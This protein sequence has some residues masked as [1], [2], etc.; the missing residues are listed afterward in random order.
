MPI[1]PPNSNDSFYPFRKAVLRGLGISMPPLLTI[2]LFLWAWTLIESYVLV[3]VESVAEVVITGASRDVL[4]TLP[5]PE[6]V[7][8]TE[9]D[10]PR[11]SREGED[12]ISFHF[13]RRVYTRSGE[14]RWVGYYPREYVR[15]N[16]TTRAKILPPFVGGLLLVLYLLGKFVAAG[17]GR[18]L[19]GFFDRLILQLPL[20]SNVYSAVKQVTDFVFVDREIEFN[21]VVAVEYP[22]KG[23][24][25]IGFVTGESMLDI[26]A[27]ANE[28]VLSVL[29]PTSPMPVTGFTITVLKSEAVDLNITVDQAIQFVVSCGVVVP[30]Q[31]LLQGQSHIAGRVTDVLATR[32]NDS[33]GTPLERPDEHSDTRDSSG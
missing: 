31:Q 25:S 29:M 23:I 24:W 22:R 8:G 32:A 20:I 5:F 28:P 13:D 7:L 16:Y 11:I 19:V 30:P 21:R 6:K 18:M 9:N 26:R 4:S 17:V 33:E 15:E 1:A 27:A 10:D 3:P 14:N 12:I 2:A